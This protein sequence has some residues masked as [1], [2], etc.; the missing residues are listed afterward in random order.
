MTRTTSQ[1]TPAPQES[2]NSDKLLSLDPRT[3]EVVGRYP[4]HG[5]EEVT[6]AVRRARE[7]GQWWAGLGFAGRKQRL[8][9]WRRRLVRRLPELANLISTETGKPIDDARLELVLVVDHLHWAAHHAERVLRRRRVSPGLLMYNHAATLE[10]QPLGVVGVI[11]PWNYPAFTPMGSIAYALAAGNAVV[12][13]PSEYTPGVGTWLADTF[14]EVVPEHPVFRVVT[15][16]GETGAALCRSGV[17]KLAFTGSTATGKRVMAA[18]AETLTPVLVECGGKDALIVDADADLEA[19]ADAAVWGGMANAGQTCVGV[20]RVYVVD[21]VADRFLDL[22]AQRARRLRAGG[23]DGADLGPITMPSQ[24]DVIRGHIQAALDAGARAVVGG[25]DSVR[26]P[27]VEPV[28]LTDVPEDCA[29]VRDETF[30]PTI[31]VNRVR[32][33]AEALRLANGTR[34]GL[35]AAV[36]SRSRGEEL[37]RRLRAG[38]VSV[39]SVISFAAVPALPFGGVGDSGFGRIHGEDGLREFARPQAVTR[40]R[41]GALLEPMSFSRGTHTVRQLLRLVRLRYGR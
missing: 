28:V 21:A 25:L 39:N 35:A 36:F 37:A 30:G 10:Y 17:D 8:D 12:F 26:A 6:D 18:C 19:A 22:V 11:G 14:A 27:Y 23:Q 20:E 33:V 41:F 5:A 16:Y 7:A 3:G 34:Y 1:S 38:M 32:D 9:A 13:K 31:T 15:G 2:E 40:R 29:A 24:V 4:V